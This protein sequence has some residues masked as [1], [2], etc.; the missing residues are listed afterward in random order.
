[1]NAEEIVRFLASVSLSSS[2]ASFE[3]KAPAGPIT[4]TVAFTLP[5]PAFKLFQAG[6]TNDESTGELDSKRFEFGGVPFETHFK[7]QKVDGKKDN[8]EFAVYLYRLGRW[9][10]D[11]CQFNYAIFAGPKNRRRC[12]VPPRLFQFIASSGDKDNWGRGGFACSAAHNELNED[13]TLEITVIVQC[14]NQSA[15]DAATS[16]YVP[17]AK[18]AATLADV[19]KHDLRILCGPVQADKKDLKDAKFGNTKTDLKTDLKVDAKPDTKSIGTA[20]GPSKESATTKADTKPYTAEIDEVGAATYV[21]AMQSPVA[22][23]LFERETVSLEQTKREWNLRPVPASAVTAMVRHAYC[24]SEA[25]VFETIQTAADALE[26]F[27]L[28]MRQ[29]VVDLAEMA[30]KS[31]TSKLSL[32]AAKEPELALEI[33]KE[34]FKSAQKHQAAIGKIDSAPAKNPIFASL[35]TNALVEAPIG[36]K[37]LYADQPPLYWPATVVGDNPTTQQFKVRFTATGATGLFD[38][39][40]LRPANWMFDQ[41]LQTAPPVSNHRRYLAASAVVKE[42][43]RKV[44]SDNLDLVDT[45]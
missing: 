25:F 27:D 2:P 45:L 13:G 9:N 36:D 6:W 8:P 18:L 29:D 22:N 35:D 3:S 24:C 14:A 38:C 32:V 20:A 4:A 1:M 41:A 43:A 26:L 11:V 7:F 34:A 28:A 15:S 21:M 17:F 23:M 33:A 16:A 31:F 37:P 39:R 5:I 12:L 19:K 42:A 40:Q 10:P 44:I 30:S